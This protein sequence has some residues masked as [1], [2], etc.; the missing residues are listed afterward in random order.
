VFKHNVM[1]LNAAQNGQGAAQRKSG[2]GCV[3]A[4]PHDAEH[5]QGVETNCRIGADA[6]R[7]AMVHRGALMSN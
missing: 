4:C 3:Q 6:L 7:Q 2:F 1:A 5:D